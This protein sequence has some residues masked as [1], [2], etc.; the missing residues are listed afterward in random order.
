M[1]KSLCLSFLSISFLVG[2]ATSEVDTKYKDVEEITNSDFKPVKQIRYNKKD[3]A[4]SDVESKYTEALNTESVERVFR[5]DGDANLKGVIGKIAELCYKKDFT[6]AKLLI[7]KHNN[8][9]LK[10]QIFWNQVGTCFLLSGERRKALLFYNKA[11]SIKSN[12]GPSLN[13]LGVMYMYERDYSRALVA[14]KRARKTSDFSRTPRFNLANLYLGFGLS[15]KAIE[16]ATPLHNSKTEDV[17]LLNILATSHLMLG[18]TK[19]ALAFF[20]RI[21]SDYFRNV[22]F[23][24]NYSL[25]LFVVGEREK[26]KDIFSDIE[27][28]PNRDWEKYFKN[29]KNYI[30]AK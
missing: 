4:F 16:E 21:D 14:F 22:R 30:G 11:L 20:E 23:G 26:A 2:C 15:Q 17:D 12:Y 3:D 8:A 24:L 28:K 1:L 9:Y 13:N 6:Q 7:K 19:T 29:V 5:Y 10:N 27:E 18:E 25:A